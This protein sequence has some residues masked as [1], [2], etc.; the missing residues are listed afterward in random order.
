MCRLTVV[1]CF[2]PSCISHFRLSSAVASCARFRRWLTSPQA[3]YL[4]SCPLY[5]QPTRY[6]I[7]GASQGAVEAFDNVQ[8]LFERE[9]NLATP[10]LVGSFGE[11]DLHHHALVILVEPR[12]LWVTGL[13]P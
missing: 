2:R 6:T 7:F 3:G 4:E 9:V 1:W 12:A 11:E 10:S 8:R 5:C 13:A